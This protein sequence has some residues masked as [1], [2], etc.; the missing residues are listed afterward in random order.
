MHLITYLNCVYCV[1]V[2]MRAVID[3]A[4]VSSVISVE[5]KVMGV[6]SVYRYFL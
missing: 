4:A 3:N 1:D 2:D 5:E 6:A